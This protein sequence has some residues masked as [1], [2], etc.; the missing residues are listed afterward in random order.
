MSED[1]GYNERLFN[2]GIR[3]QVHLARFAWL[4]K[5]MSAYSISE[6]PRV[7]EL[8]CFDGRSIDWLPTEPSLYDGFD[9]NWEGGLDIGRKH[10]AGRSNIH[11]HQ[12]SS[13]DQMTMD[14][15]GYDIGISLE[16]MEHVPPDMVNGYLEKFA[17][18]VKTAVFFTVPNEIGIPFAIKSSQKRSF[19][20]IARMKPIQPPNSGMR[21]WDEQIWS[22]AMS[23]RDLITV[24][25][26]PR[27]KNI[28]R[29][30]GLWVYL[31]P[32]YLLDC[33]L[34]SVL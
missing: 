17:Q 2:S 24:S 8:G 25:L 20:G 15:G 4:R 10:F 23:T 21:F 9:A 31:M 13:P 22:T 7:L 14:A 30:K 32:G 11:F 33:P 12:C 5:M 3:K 18:N 34:P 6:T 19:I 26:Y 28:L 16:T 1:H 29:S 27:W